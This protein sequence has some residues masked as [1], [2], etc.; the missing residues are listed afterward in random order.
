MNLNEQLLQDISGNYHYQGV[1]AKP[2]QHF[3]NR[4]EWLVVVGDHDA[5][6]H[7]VWFCSTPSLDVRMICVSA[8]D[9]YIKQKN[10]EANPPQ[11]EVVNDKPKV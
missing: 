7:K 2:H 4:N 5:T 11:A 3:T 10:A 8:I 1:Q 6:E 9:W